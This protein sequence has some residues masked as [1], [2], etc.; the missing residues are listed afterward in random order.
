MI[1]RFRIGS[2]RFVHLRL[3][4]KRR[5]FLPG[6]VQFISVSQQSARQRCSLGHRCRCCSSSR[7]R[8]VRPAPPRWSP[9]GSGPAG[10]SS[11]RGK[12][13]LPRL[14][15]QPRSSRGGPASASPLPPFA[16]C[17]RRGC[18]LRQEHPKGRRFG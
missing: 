11:R 6:G 8:S 5:R 16:G 1:V 13:L 3:N 2:V 9:C 12:I 15:P 14:S 4:A 7:T 18:C 10:G 17:G